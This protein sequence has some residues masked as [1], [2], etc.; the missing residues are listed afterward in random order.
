MCFTCRAIPR[1]DVGS[2]ALQMAKQV[3]VRLL[4]GERPAT[5]NDN[6]WTSRFYVDVT[7]VSEDGAALIGEDT[8]T[9]DV[10]IDHRAAVLSLDGEFEQ[11]TYGQQIRQVGCETR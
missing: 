4:R 3:S 8:H 1:P 6:D 10:R 2:V 5:D 7:Q 11:L 9:A